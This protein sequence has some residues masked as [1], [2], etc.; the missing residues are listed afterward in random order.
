LFDNAIYKIA[1]DEADELFHKKHSCTYQDLKIGEY[2]FCE[3][4]K[5]DLASAGVPG[6]HVTACH[7]LTCWQSVGN[8][9]NI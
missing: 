6:R 8:M 5:V 2:C 9:T 3:A 4:M 1:G 7:L